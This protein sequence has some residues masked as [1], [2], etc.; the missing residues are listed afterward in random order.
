M[1][2]LSPV[3]DREL[4]QINSYQRWE[5]AFH[6]FSYVL[7]SR[8]PSKATELLQYNHTIHMSLSTCLWENIYAYNKEFR[9]HI[10]WHSQWPWNMILQQAWTMLIKDR[11]KKI[12]YSRGDTKINETRSHVDAL[13]EANVHL[14]CH[15]SLTI[16]AQ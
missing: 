4:V 6:V 14:V 12:P 2:F 5:Q 10:L 9:R 15:A 11:L 7:T 1:S 8:Y 3:G 13:T 16:T